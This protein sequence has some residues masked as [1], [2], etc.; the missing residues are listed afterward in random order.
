MAFG[1]A[2]LLVFV[3]SK[4][5]RLFPRTSSCY[6]FGLKSCKIDMVVDGSRF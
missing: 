2:L 6:Y 5:D 1:S 3:L 4:N